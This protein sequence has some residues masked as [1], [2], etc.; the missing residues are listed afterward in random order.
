MH[1]VKKE[2]SKTTKIRAV[3]DASAKSSTGVSLNDTLLVGPTIHP[4]LLDALLCFCLHHMALVADV[5]RMYCAIELTKLDR[6]L[7]QFVWRR[8]PKDPLLDYHMSQVTF[9]VSA[10]LFA[11]NMSIKQ[12]AIDFAMD[13]P[14]AIDAVNRAFYVDDRLT[15]ADSTEEAIELQ[16]QLQDLFS[17]GGFLLHK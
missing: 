14:L 12:S 3:F 15:G 8:N 4:P 5:S 16:R 9:S 7:H 10:S 2:S 17:R 11:A 13:Y 6:D 1:A